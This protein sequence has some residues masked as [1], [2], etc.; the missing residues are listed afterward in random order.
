MRLA[1]PIFKSLQGEGPNIGKPAI[2]I[3]LAGC[4]LRCEFCDSKFSW[5]EG[6]EVSIEE[7]VNKIKS[8]RKIK[9]IVITGGEPLLQ[10]KEIRKLIINIKKEYYNNS[11]PILYAFELETNGTI[12][13]NDIL[14]YFDYVSVSPKENKI[15]DAN[16]INQIY[17][18]QIIF[19]FV[20]ENR[21]SFI[22]WK[23]CIENLGIS[24]SQVYMMPQ[25]RT[26]KEFVINGKDLS[27]LCI[28]HGFRF[29][30]RLQLMLWDNK[31][32]V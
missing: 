4:N 30:P 31:R 32:G 27:N 29:A 13:Y 22:L 11:K 20:V 14:M 9:H 28:E 16:L 25:S 6:K 12:W 18:R 21:E 7:I 10:Y 8:Y 1:E 24:K 23:N 3:R 2:F 17:N 19:K 26:R 5:V 15:L